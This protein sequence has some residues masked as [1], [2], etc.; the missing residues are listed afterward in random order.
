VAPDAAGRA[1]R[2]ERGP[3]DDN[4]NASQRTPREPPPPRT[5][6]LGNGEAFAIGTAA[7]MRAAAAWLEENYPDGAQGERYGPAVGPV[8]N[9]GASNALAAYALYGGKVPPTSLTLLVYMALVSLDTDTEPWWSQGHAM[10]AIQCLGRD[11][12]VET[13]DEEEDRK[14]ARAAAAAVERAVKPLFGA[15]AITVARHSSGHPGRHINVRYRLWLVKPAP[16]EL[17]PRLYRNASPETGDDG[18]DPS[19]PHGNRGVQNPRADSSER[20]ADMSAPHEIHGAPD[21]RTPRNPSPHPTETMTAP[22]ENRA[23]KEYEE[24]EEREERQ[25]NMVV[26]SDSVPLRAREAGDEDGEV[27]QRAEPG[28]ADAPCPNPPAAASDATTTPAVDPD[29]H[30]ASELARLEA[31]IAEHPETVTQ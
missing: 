3:D 16:D 28:G 13:G 19:V 27:D 21:V 9:M 10:L 7:G 5:L 6:D 23:P 1:P 14:A 25:E 31:W 8:L 22:H 26:S 30:R 2:Q 18:P 11:P 15:G 4:D 12:L 17:R 20:R 29:E 24:Y